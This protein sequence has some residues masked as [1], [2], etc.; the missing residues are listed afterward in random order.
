MKNF[1]TLLLLGTA[2]QF[3]PTLM[4]QDGID[5]TEGRVQKIDHNAKLMVVKTAQGVEHT[6]R[7][8]GHAVVRTGKS[9]AKGTSNAFHDL[10]VGSEVAVHYSAKGTEKTVE[11]IDH[12]GKDGLKA[13]KGTIRAID[14][15]A[16]TVAVKTAEGAEL[17]FGLTERSAVEMGKHFGEGTEKAAKITI[18]Y[19][20]EAGRKVGHFFKKLAD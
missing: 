6:F 2:M 4:A 1:M 7:L 3:L 9:A 8:A 16:K 5:V 13:V 11:E 10:K 14:W 17:T 20:E 19:T 15:S 18:Y 12:V